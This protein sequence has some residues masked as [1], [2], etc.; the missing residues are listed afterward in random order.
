MTNGMFFTKRTTIRVVFW[1]R[2][3]PE[4]LL[5]KGL[6]RE[7]IRFNLP[8]TWGYMEEKCHN[9]KTGFHSVLLINASTQ[10]VV[11]NHVLCLNTNREVPP[12]FGLKYDENYKNLKS[13]EDLSKSNGNIW[14]FS[15]SF[16]CC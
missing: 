2:R 16:F 14:G 12:K 10:I 7:I 5:E 6:C 15:F 1:G 8:E 13:D 9:L 3:S 4:F 11:S